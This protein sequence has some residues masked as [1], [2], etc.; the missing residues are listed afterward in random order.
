[1]SSDAGMFWAALGGPWHDRTRFLAYDGHTEVGTEQ[2][3]SQAKGSIG[4]KT[5]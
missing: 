1:M 5:G 4:E 3:R 2:D